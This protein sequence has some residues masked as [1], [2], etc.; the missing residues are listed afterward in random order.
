MM[1]AVNSNSPSFYRCRSMSKLSAD[2]VRCWLKTILTS[3]RT[4][5]FMLSRNY[6]EIL[7]SR[8]HCLEESMKVPCPGLNRQIRFNQ[9]FQ[10]S[11]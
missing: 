6:P 7:G 8:Q 11:T 3:G 9:H 4:V 2:F 5:H 10:R 1:A